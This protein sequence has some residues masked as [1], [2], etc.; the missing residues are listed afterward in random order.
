[1]DSEIRIIRLIRKA[2]NK[3][4]DT[5]DKDAENTYSAT[6]YFDTMQVSKVE[7]EA[8]FAKM[9]GVWPHDKPEVSNIVAQSYS[10]YCSKEMI[11]GEE[12][13]NRCGDPFSMA[14]GN[15]SRPFLS[16]IQ[17]HIMPEI[18]AYALPE[19]AT[20]E[21]LN[22]VYKDLCEALYGCS[23]KLHNA[24]YILRIYKMLSA[25][26]F[27]I[28]IRSRN[29]EVS[30]RIS[31]M[32]RSR[33]ISGNQIL[34]NR[35]ELVLYKT[36]TL[37][38]FH[39]E[40]I[41]QA[42]DATEP[43]FVLRCCFSNRYWSQKTE[44]DHFLDD[45]TLETDCAEA[46]VYGLNGRYDLTFWISETQFL[47]LYESIQDYRQ[48]GFL[49]E[50]VEYSKEGTVSIVEYI[51]YLMS[52]QAFSYINIRYL[53]AQEKE[54][55]GDEDNICNA[56]IAVPADKLQD[57]IEYL[58]E[59]IDKF[60]NLV[61]E[62]YIRA[63]EE[64][65][66]I[67]AYRKNMD[68]YIELLDKLVVLCFGINDSSDTRIYAAILL[69]QLDIVLDSTSVYVK[70]YHMSMDGSEQTGILDAL[71]DCIRQSVWALN[72][73]A[74][75]IRNNNLQSIQTPNYNIE[76]SMSMEKLLIGY[77][78]LL[79][80]FMKFYR[81]KYYSAVN[82]GQDKERIYLPIVIPTLFKS[83]MSVDVLFMEGVMDDWK[84]EESVWN[85]QTADKIRHCMVVSVPT[86]MEL[87]DIGTMVISLFH[88]VAH[89]FRYE[90]RSDRNDALYKY[91]IH[92]TMDRVAEKVIQ[93]LQGDTGCYDWDE[94]LQVYLES[95]LSEAYEDIFK[96]DKDKYSFSQ[97]PLSSFSYC[98]QR[99]LYDNLYYEDGGLDL[100]AKL[101][102]YL[103]DIKYYCS[104]GDC[105]FREI[106]R[107]FENIPKENNKIICNQM[108]CCAYS[109][110]LVGACQITEMSGKEIWSK[111]GLK[112]WIMR[113]EDFDARADWDRFFSNCSQEDWV[114]EKM[115]HL[116]NDF[117]GWLCDNVH[118]MVYNASDT[119]SIQDAFFEKAYDC[120][121]KKWQERKERKD[122]RKD[123]S[124]K[125]EA[126]GRTLGI[127]QCLKE[128]L[129]V[130]KKEIRPIIQQ[131][132]LELLDGVKWR[133][134]K[135]REETADLLMC[136]AMNLSPFGY[137]CLLAVNLP[138]DTELSD[139][140]ISR[141]IN[142]LIFC[143]NCIDSEGRVSES[144]FITICA[145]MLNQLEDSLK[146]L[147]INYGEESREA[148]SLPQ[149][150]ENER[151]KDALLN[152]MDKISI[153]LLEDRKLYRIIRNIEII[154]KNAILFGERVTQ[155]LND[156][157]ELREDYWR[158]AKKLDHLN[159]DMCGDP[160][161][162]VNELGRFC[163]KIGEIQNNL[164]ICR[165][166]VEKQKSM[167]EESVIF[168]LNM[169]YQNKRRMAREMREKS[170]IE[171]GDC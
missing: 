106:M 167:N 171:K 112:K 115:W 65:K 86:L 133:I 66:S 90:Q 41:S 5:E 129:K 16:I 101:Q 127:D 163:K 14:G 32:L 34:G 117:S 22:I 27:A 87:T 130:F 7:L 153:P 158:G 159:E 166:D 126:M 123:P 62:K 48:R 81:R 98:L 124:R 45:R 20:D 151:R 105:K 121:C 31:S 168:L 1:M 10:L 46:K 92:V 88:E 145:Q 97:F 91:L 83:D 67:S 52:R 143:G 113:G 84:L 29:A 104:L 69:E 140:Y 53:V 23:E 120:C 55:S 13:R 25:G 8:P 118:Q 36:Y 152:R 6:D 109:I 154:I 60:Y 17:V 107:I 11:L 30:F 95:S 160:D 148:I 114:C 96:G 3:N 162:I 85:E 161:S 56:Q 139:E 50:A 51:K 68:Q 77:G 149:D 135:Y 102:E 33:H 147:G 82:E 38:T 156:Y 12:G 78:E 141:C 75:Y 2:A 47:N 108:I 43:R 150:Q 131:N 74:Q 4:V 9:M 119:S 35:N 70:L 15:S 122:W 71:E 89:Q 146:A 26:D 64:L 116:F 57:K 37:L 100:K 132:L 110:A 164:L 80:V 134:G 142:V 39:Q 19:K 94:E 42:G 72:S 76:S 28:A 111:V 93:K 137:V 136:K 165:N 128:N 144:A 125:L 24:D 103:Q 49:K 59:Q 157:V 58:D 73:Y 21:L 63:S 18:L 61:T 169:Y 79:F 138:I 54:V 44:I 40:V 99:Q 170:D 155:Y